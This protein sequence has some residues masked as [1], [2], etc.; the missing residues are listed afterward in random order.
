MVKLVIFFFLF[1]GILSVTR[2]KREESKDSPGK[3]EDRQS[4]TTDD[5]EGQETFEQKFLQLSLVVLTLRREI[6]S[7]QAELL[8]SR[9]RSKGEGGD[10]G[11]LGNAG[12]P[13]LEGL[14]G[15]KGEPGECC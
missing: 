15:P 2:E 14:H 8:S 9:P 4:E 5:S 7:L 10:R 11:D 13:G 3:L 1:I 6:A 12:R